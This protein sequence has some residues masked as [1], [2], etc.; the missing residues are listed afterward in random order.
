MD[1]KQ[2]KLT[3]GEEIVGQVVEWPEEDALEIVAKNMM[4]VQVV[5][6]SDGSYY[7]TL[8]PFLTYQLSSDNLILINMAQIVAE[9]N[10]T[11]EVLDQYKKVLESHLG[12][13][14]GEEKATMEDLIL[15]MGTPDNKIH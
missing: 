15:R 9:A 13:N 3:T 7:H 5:A 14:E 11:Q 12:E 4:K 2:F 1:M 8:L 6:S 10:P